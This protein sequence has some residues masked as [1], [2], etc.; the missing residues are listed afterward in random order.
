MAAKVS[1]FKEGHIILLKSSRTMTE[2]DIMA[3][4][5][6]VYDYMSE[7]TSPHVHI[8]IDDTD[9]ESMPSVHSY[10]ALQSLKHPKMGWTIV[11]GLNNKVFRMMYAIVCH[12]KGIPLYMAESMEEAAQFIQQT[13]VQPVPKI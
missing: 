8:I 10:K 7:A 11:V 9:V 3:L 12:I 5:P 2:A 4:D 6:I 1:W 13:D